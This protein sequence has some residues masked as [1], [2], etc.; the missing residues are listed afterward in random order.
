M[1]HQEIV[2]S[3]TG[4]SFYYDPPEGRPSG[5]PT[6]AVHLSDVDDDGLLES[7]TTG[8]CSVD[9]VNTTLGASATHGDDSITLTSATGVTVGRRYLLTTLGGTREWIEVLALVGT[10]A[11]LR[12]PLQNDHTTGST[13]QGCRISIDVDST[14]VASKNKLTNWDAGLAGYRLRWSYV[15]DST[16]RIGASY[17][18]LTRYPLATLVTPLDV[19]AMS[20]GWIDRLPPDYQ[21]DQGAALVT[22]ASQAVRMDAMADGHVLRL[23]RNTEVLRELVIKRAI[24]MATEHAAVAGAA[25]TDARQVAKDAYDRRY[26]QLLREPHVAVDAGGGGGGSIPPRTPPWVR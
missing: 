14:W 25:N 4:Q 1:R 7:A 20:P 12:R 9:S 3:V 17:A 23:V 2:Y 18:D 19:D 24:W 5:T 26:A 21:A 6:V 15:V 22:E 13:F 8:A 11:T 10:A 16:T